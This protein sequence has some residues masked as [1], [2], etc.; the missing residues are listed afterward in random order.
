MNFSN[1]KAV[2]YLV[3][4]FQYFLLIGYIKT[5]TVLKRQQFK[6]S[7]S[8]KKELRISKRQLVHMTDNE[9]GQSL[10]KYEDEDEGE[11]VRY[12]SL[13]FVTLASPRKES[14]RPTDMGK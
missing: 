6:N 13:P 3:D 10:D 9:K 14:N 5:A 1:Q 2:Y 12:V 7:E 8:E 11:D 4:Q